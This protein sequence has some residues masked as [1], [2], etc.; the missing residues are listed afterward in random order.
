MRE[1]ID[2]SK[3][4]YVQKLNQKVSDSKNVVSIDKSKSK[5]KPKQSKVKSKPQ[6]TAPVLT[7]YAV[8]HSTAGDTKMS[9]PDTAEN[10][11][12][13]TNT[14]PSTATSKNNNSIPITRRSSA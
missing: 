7:P 12:T 2:R 10:T 4:K 9:R 13:S 14:P 11:H 6:Q 8:D 3:S 1:Q 5:S